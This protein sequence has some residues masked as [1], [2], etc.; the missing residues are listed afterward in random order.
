MTRFKELQIVVGYSSLSKA[1]EYHLQLILLTSCL[2]ATAVQHSRAANWDGCKFVTH[3]RNCQESWQS[4]FYMHCIGSC[5]MQQ[6]M[7]IGKC[8]FYINV[9]STL[10][11]FKNK[12]PNDSFSL[13][14]FKFVLVLCA[15]VV[16]VAFNHGGTSHPDAVWCTV[17]TRRCSWHSWNCSLSPLWTQPLNWFK[18]N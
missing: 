9:N 17:V 12:T 10:K 3:A 11:L 7:D 18:E 13:Q 5:T 14:L 8:I 6:L 4:K 15:H 2:P 16:A 1:L